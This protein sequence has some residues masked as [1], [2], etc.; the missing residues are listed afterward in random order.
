MG[1]PNVIIV[2]GG[3][4]GCGIALRL[5]QSGAS[6]TIVER[7][8]PGAEASSAAAGVLAPQLEAEGPGHFLELCLR[9]RALYPSFA[10]EL[11]SLSGI[12]IDYRS[13]GVLKVAFSE[14][15]APR[16]EAMVAWQ[17]ASG[18]RAELLA[19]S[20]ALG[21]EPNLS[22]RV[23][24]AVYLPDDHQV[25]NRLLVRALSIAA[26]R[27]GVAFRI[28]S[29][30]SVAAEGDR[31]IGVDVDGE[32]LRSDAVVI[33]AGSWSSLIQGIGIPA[34]SVKPMRGQMVQLQADPSLLR[35]ALIEEHSYVVPRTDGRVL[36]G[37][38]FELAGYER[39]V[40]AEGVK[41]ILERALEL[42]PKLAQAPIA[43]VW[44]GLRPYTEDQL[45]ILGT[46]PLRGLFFATGHFRTGILLAPIT[47]KVISQAVM[48]QKTAVDLKPFAFDRL[49]HSGPRSK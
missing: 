11:Q 2:G 41:T 42:C 47:A 36:A 29:A 6:V 13:A 10:E 4:I 27:A 37:T 33:A 15:L 39:R 43:E 23:A 35:L 8:A 3:A 12:S 34:R 48:G 18:L 24:V 26:A 45:P 20:D 28:G 44:A 9:S 17:K 19:P 32:L 40:T 16:F 5:A 49:E 7:T 21:L 22:P 30:R 38:T 25:D 46:G 14:D 1:S 31:A